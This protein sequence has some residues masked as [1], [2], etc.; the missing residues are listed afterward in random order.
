MVPPPRRQSEEK[1][2]FLILLL[3]SC[4]LRL[5]SDTSFSQQWR[6]WKSFFNGLNI[7]DFSGAGSLGVIQSCWHDNSKMLYWT[8]KLGAMENFAPMLVY[9]LSFVYVGLYNIL[10]MGA[11]LPYYFILHKLFG[12]FHAQL[13]CMRSLRHE[14]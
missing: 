7:I 2:G 13:C 3:I 10:S 1:L 6:K 14:L 9:V 8:R 11:C 5:N 4:L 12:I